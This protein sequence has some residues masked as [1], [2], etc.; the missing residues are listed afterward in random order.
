MNAPEQRVVAEEA[1][2]AFDRSSPA[3]EV[4]LLVGIRGV[5]A[6][7]QESVLFLEPAALVDASLNVVIRPVAA[8]ADRLAGDALRTKLRVGEE[9][10]AARRR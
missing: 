10:S 3:S 7:N 8:N 6:D 2:Q 9:A 5:A 1:G 4:R